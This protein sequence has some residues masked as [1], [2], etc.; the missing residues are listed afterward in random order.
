MVWAGPAQAAQ[1]NSVGASQI[2]ALLHSRAAPGPTGINPLH[3]PCVRPPSGRPD[4]LPPPPAA[5]YAAAA[6]RLPS[7]SARALC[8]FKKAVK[9]GARWGPGRY[10]AGIE[11]H[12]V[13]PSLASRCRGVAAQY[14][15]VG[16]AP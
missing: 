4:A 3:A 11:H 14:P 5:I 12:R 8:L 7:R 10:L 2:P 1:L 6:Y 15:V 13:Q 16:H 9:K